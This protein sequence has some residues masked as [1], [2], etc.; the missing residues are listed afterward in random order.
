[1]VLEKNSSQAS[2]YDFFVNP[3]QNQSAVKTF[4]GENIE[5]PIADV[6]LRKYLNEK[7]ISEMIN[8]NSEITRILNKF[9]I[10]IKIN[11]KILNNL[12]QNHLPDTRKTALGIANNLP[13]N[14]KSAIN[15]KALIEA[16]TLHDIA[17]AIIPEN[18][19]NKEGAL[20]EDER[21]IMKEHAKLSYEMLKT[22]DL[23]E[24]TLNL[25]KNHHQNPQKTGYP[26]TDEAFVSDINLQI[27]SMADIYSALREKRSYKNAL[28]KDQALE[29]I[30]KETEEGK[31][32]PCVYNALV[33]Y[34]NREE[35]LAK[36]KSKWQIFN[37]KFA[38]S[39]SS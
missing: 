1:M 24:E 14:F 9:K 3:I 19:V 34:A 22:T 2:V 36:I 27:L 21:E 10:S 28:S 23:S 31:F 16:T 11:M 18:I 6:T 38:D 7:A 15:R 13:H 30:N 12:V 4:I 35:N 17:K 29:I 39:F 25:I 32:H 26:N 33:A 5:S 37:F 8:V 20:T